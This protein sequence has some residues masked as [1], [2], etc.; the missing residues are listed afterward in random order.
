MEK[1]SQTEIN[2]LLASIEATD[3]E[4]EEK[5]AT[6]Y[7]F[8]Y[9][10]LFSKKQLHSISYAFENAAR[11][12]TTCFSKQMGG[13]IHFHVEAV[14]QMT[15]EE[16]IRSVP[17]PLPM[18]IANWGKYKTLLGIGRDAVS[19]LI[20]YSTFKVLD[21]TLP[22]DQASDIKI[23]L[24]IKELSEA[25]KILSRISL[26]S[27]VYHHFIDALNLT[28]R[29]KLNLDDSKKVLLKAPEQLYIETNPQFAQIANPGNTVVLITMEINIDNTTE[30]MINF[31]M[32]ES[33]VRNL[34]VEPGI[35]EDSLAL[36]NNKLESNAVVSVGGFALENQK[37]EA[38]KIIPL[39]KKTFE[40]VDILD[41]KTGKILA[42]GKI[43]LDDESFAVKIL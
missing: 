38:G 39:D 20:N 42:K 7:N 19:A 5:E 15:F 11:T 13:M 22:Y 6:E 40:A 9:Q 21:K 43:I 23:S 25:E 3:K 37:L 1:L 29:K 31:V 41:V 28:G 14:E 16:F 35:I 10:K 2:E 33:F 34:L 12:L 30:D 24:A 26:F 27:P 8:N 36:K 18:G 32:P 4:V 17:T